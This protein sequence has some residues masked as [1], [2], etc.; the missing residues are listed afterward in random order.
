MKMIN[1]NSV[2]VIL[3]NNNWLKTRIVAIIVNNFILSF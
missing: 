2:S 1:V 3:E